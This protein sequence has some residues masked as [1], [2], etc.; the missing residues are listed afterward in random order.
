MRIDGDSSM[1]VIN[2]A[3]KQRFEQDFPETRVT[4]A[5][6]GTDI[7]LQSLQEGK[8]DLATIGRSLTAAEKSAGLEEFPLEREKIAI[9]SARIIPSRAISP[10]ANLPKFS[11]RDYGLV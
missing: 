10:F 4:T 3:L 8:L 7:A 1:A 6:Q 9:L 5:T 2:Q 11:R